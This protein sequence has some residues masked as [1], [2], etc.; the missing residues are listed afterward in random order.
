MEDKW[1][2]AKINLITI[3]TAI[4]VIANNNTKKIIPP[5]KEAIDLPKETLIVSLIH[6]II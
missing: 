6:V 3:I 4:T 1:I 5:E 2:I